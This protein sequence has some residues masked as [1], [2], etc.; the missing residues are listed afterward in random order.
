[1]LTV[2]Q[3]A[4]SI[5]QHG[6]LAQATGVKREKGAVWAAARQ[7]EQGRFRLQVGSGSKVLVLQRVVEGGHL[8]TADLAHRLAPSFHH[9]NQI[10]SEASQ[11]VQT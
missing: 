9:V 8:G 11:I 5:Q 3:S 10:T 6:V 2:R 4:A 1:M 7:I